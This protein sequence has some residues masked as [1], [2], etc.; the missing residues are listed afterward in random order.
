MKENPSSSKDEL[1]QHT[2]LNSLDK[3]S[4]MHQRLFTH[5]NEAVRYQIECVQD[6]DY[7][8]VHL[9]YYFDFVNIKK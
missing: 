6:V 3:Q 7:R 5:V 8:V 2:G 4:V 9:I 1:L